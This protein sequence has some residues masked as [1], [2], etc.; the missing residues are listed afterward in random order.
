MCYCWLWNSRYCW[1]HARVHMQPIHS[2][3]V[4]NT[5]Q[6]SLGNRFD[7]GLMT[8]TMTATSASVTMMSTMTT[9]IHY[10]LHLKSKIVPIVR[11]TQTL[12]IFHFWIR[13]FLCAL[14]SLASSL[15]CP[16]LLSAS[17]LFYSLVLLSLI[18]SLFFFYFFLFHKRQYDCVECRLYVFKSLLSK[19]PFGCGLQRNIFTTK[20]NSINHTHERKRHLTQPE[21]A[22]QT[23]HGKFFNKTKIARASS[24]AFIF[25]NFNYS[26]Q[27]N[28]KSYRRVSILDDVIHGRPE[29]KSLELSLSCPLIVN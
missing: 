21:L 29:I 16:I 4:E 14:F 8:T 24:F 5:D 26:N 25:T 18:T 12:K 15:S 3:A 1:W 2:V 28:F 19:S 7:C 22:W 27:E 20:E 10:P 6:L 9:A 23:F 17:W 13:P 11:R